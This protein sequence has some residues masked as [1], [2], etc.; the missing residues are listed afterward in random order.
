LNSMKKKNNRICFVNLGCHK[1]LVDAEIISGALD[2][3]GFELIDNPSEAQTIIVNTCGFLEV[4]RQESIESIKEMSLYR[5]SGI[6]ER[7]VVTGCMADQDRAL[8]LRAVPEIDQFVS[9]FQ[10]DQIPELI[11]AESKETSVLHT[12]DFRW[13]KAPRWLAT[14]ESYAF[15]KTSDG[16]DNHC[17]Y[18]RIPYLRGNFRSK[19]RTDILAEA[20]DI[21]DTGRS[22]IVLI[23]QDN[24]S[25]GKDDQSIGGFTDLVRG[26][27]DLDGLRRLRIMYMYPSRI[28][29]ELLELMASSNNICNYLDIPL[30]HVNTRVLKNMNRSLPGFC[31]ESALNAIDFIKD[32]RKS[33]PNIVIRTTLMT[34]F[35]GEDE[36]AFCNLEDF[37]ESGSIDHLGVFPWSPEPETPSWSWAEESQMDIAE[38]RAARLLELQARVV[39]NR[40]AS[41]LGEVREIIIDEIEEDAEI[42]STGRMESQAPEVDGN[43]RIQGKFTVG[44]Y[45]TTR[46]ENIDIFD[47]T[48]KQSGNLV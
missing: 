46:L 7:L 5:I 23:S 3:A 14:P 33:V 4:A 9:S 40:N 21:L 11:Q 43:V 28:D 26:L 41:L 17:S 39:E 8:L 48:G 25:Y 1:N 32:I 10:L 47:F 19:L 12:C 16:C 31:D 18:C 37:I 45:V 22:E 42:W 34:G 44:T 27:S 6:L 24:S 36:E 2:D 29:R 35:P 13:A 15:L 38:E 30:Q 20:A